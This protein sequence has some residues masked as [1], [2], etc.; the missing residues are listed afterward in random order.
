MPGYITDRDFDKDKALATLSE[1]IDYAEAIVIGAGAGLSTSA[2]FEYGGARFQNNFRGYTQK[3]GFSDMYSGGFFPYQ[4]SNEF[5]AFWA[6]AIMLNRYTPAPKDTYFKLLDL[7]KDKNY[8]VLTTNVDHQ[9]QTSGFE[10][11]RLFYTQGDYGLFQCNTPCCQETWD[12]EEQVREMFS[13][14]SKDVGDEFY[15]KIPTELI[16]KCPHCDVQANMNLRCDD[17]FVEDAGWHEHCKLYEKFLND[18]SGKRILYLDL[19]VGMN[20][21]GIIKYPFW[22]FTKA[23]KN[24]FY[25]CVNYGQAFAPGEIASQSVCIN[26]D[27]DEIISQLVS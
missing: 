1:Q 19:G 15:F 13:A 5:W 10:K 23:N 17:S 21:P 2:G 3:Y 7:V 14:L 24:A 22:R 11:E 6:R 18:N 25:A 16:P 12:N 4:T 8:F 20:T 26:A 9:F 27:L